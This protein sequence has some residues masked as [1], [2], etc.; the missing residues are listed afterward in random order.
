MNKHK[1][2]I[3]GFIFGGF[4]S[5]IFKVLQ[6]TKCKKYMWTEIKMDEIAKEN[7]MKK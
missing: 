3:V 1:F 7:C 6:C 2:K 4:N 5:N